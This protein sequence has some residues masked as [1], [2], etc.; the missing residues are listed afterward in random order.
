MGN[1]QVTFPRPFARSS[2]R[3]PTAGWRSRRGEAL[4]PKP[5]GDGSGWLCG[6]LR[7]PL[8]RDDP[9]G[10]G[11]RI[12]FQVLP[13]RDHS[14]PARDAI[15]VTAG[16][17]GESATADRDTWAS[18]L[19]PLLD[20]RDLVVVDNRGTGGSGAIDCR[21]LQNGFSAGDELAKAVAACGAQLGAASDRYGTGDA[22]LDLE[23]VRKALAI[24]Q[25][26]YFGR[27][28]AS[29]AEQAYAVRFPE[30]L[31]SIVIDAGLTVSDP[32]HQFGWGF[33][34]P[35]AAVRAVEF[36]CGRAPACS[37]L[38]PDPAGDLT[39][40]ID[41][42]RTAPVVGDALDADNHLR[43]VVVDEAELV[44]IVLNGVL[45]PGE[46]PAAAD[47]LRDGDQEPLL[48][49]GAENPQGFGAGGVPSVFSWGRQRRGVLQ[50]PGLRVRQDR[51]A[52]GSTAAVRFGARGATDRFIRSVL[53]VCDGGVLRTRALS[54]L[55]RAYTDRTGGHSKR[56][57]SRRPDACAL[58]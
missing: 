23:D 1:R 32:A 6:K 55:A 43:H 30:H 10:K 11:I 47:A 14:P 37:R 39:W 58:R 3:G 33:G 42:V 16:G 53:K 52:R 31:R 48:R 20:S 40:L 4:K 35:E 24:D 9:A 56:R 41:R 28:Y 57:L 18:I 21:D 29:V 19:D 12:A 27:S 25:I 34:L 17:P 54:H 7:V 5:C 15:F 26:D 49:L 38:H 22:A 50:R 2:H 44:T 46:I 13:H 36:S 45:N 8:D 51:V